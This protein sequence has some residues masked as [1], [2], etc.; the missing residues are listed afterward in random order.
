MIRA[1][2]WLAL[3][4]GVHSCGKVH[5]DTVQLPPGEHIASTSADPVKPL[6]FNS[7]GELIW[8]GHLVRTPSQMRKVML[9]LARSLRADCRP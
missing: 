2:A 7:A 8:R 4:I 5:A 6:S 1:I 9:Y 3:A